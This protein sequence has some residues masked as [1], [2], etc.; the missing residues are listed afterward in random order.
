MIAYGIPNCRFPN[1]LFM[2]VALVLMASLLATMTLATSPL[3]LSWGRRASRRRYLFAFLLLLGLVVVPTL[4]EMC[5]D[6]LLDCELVLHSSFQAM[7]TN[8]Q[9]IG[10][11]MRVTSTS[12]ATTFQ[13]SSSKTLFNS[14]I[15]FTL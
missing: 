13:C 3:H 9:K 8:H 4:L 1:V 10:T 11:L 5:T 12:L 2:L 14:L 15:S 6:L 7:R